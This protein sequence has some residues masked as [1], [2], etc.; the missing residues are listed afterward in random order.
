M[1]ATLTAGAAPS[2]PAFVLALPAIFLGVLINVVAQHA[3]AAIAFWIRDARTTWFL[4]Q[5]LV[6]I[7]GGMLLPLQV[8]PAA[9]RTLAFALPFSAMA[10]VPA[11]LASGHFEPWLLLV[12]LAWLGI[13]VVVARLVFSIGERRLQVVGG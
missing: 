7:F 13:V 10:Y 4:Y 11:R 3:F 8:L 5:K 9:L 1:L 12:Q 2:W 6:F